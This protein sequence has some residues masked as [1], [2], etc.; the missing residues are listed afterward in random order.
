MVPRAWPVP[1]LK[2][3]HFGYKKI[4]L[5]FF[6][7]TNTMNVLETSPALK[8]RLFP[9]LFDHF[10]WYGQTVSQANGLL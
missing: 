9:A 2:Y 7:V 8:S 4:M 10:T 1:Q 6:Q 3:N 5:E